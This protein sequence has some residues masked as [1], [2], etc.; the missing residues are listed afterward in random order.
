M[1]ARGDGSSLTAYKST[2]SNNRAIRHGAA[3]YAFNEGAIKATDTTFVYNAATL[4]GGA[5]STYESTI[6]ATDCAFDSNMA[7]STGGAISGY[8]GSIVTT[9]GCTYT[10][11]RA[12]YGGVFYMDPLSTLIN[13]RA[14]TT[15]GGN[16]ATQSGDIAVMASSSAE[17][18][19]VHMFFVCTG[20]EFTDDE[21]DGSAQEISYPCMACGEGTYG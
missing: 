19:I 7:N 2:F 5:L 14:S 4:Y 16:T 3:M 9:T 17:T 11:N 8:A 10:N 21:Y 20:R 15:D 1:Y 13:I 6:D 18:E 12:P